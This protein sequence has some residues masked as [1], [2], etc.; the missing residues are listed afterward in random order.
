MRVDFVVPGEPQGKGRPRFSSR[1]GRT[2]ARTPEATVVYENLIRV[3]YERQCYGHRYDDSDMLSLQVIAHYGIPSSASKRKK[4]DMVTG[5]IRPTKKPDADNVL[6]VV[7][8]SLNQIAYRD[9]AQIV[10]VQVAKF[11][12]HTPRLSISIKNILEEKP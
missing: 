9:D 10:N 8:D 2:F 1:V 4:Q 3:E 11:Y 7:A 6:K 5:K 12:S